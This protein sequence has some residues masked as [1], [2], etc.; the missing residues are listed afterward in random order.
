MHVYISLTYLLQL[1]TFLLGGLRLPEVD[2]T[3]LSEE[4]CTFVS[5]CYKM[6]LK[7]WNSATNARPSLKQI[8]SFFNEQYVSNL[9][10]IRLLMPAY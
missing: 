4:E 10:L 5:E 3:G 2:T 7:C 8:Q 1:L 9:I 6:M